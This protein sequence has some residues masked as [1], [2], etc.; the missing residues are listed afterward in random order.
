MAASILP[1]MMKDSNDVDGW[2]CKKCDQ[3]NPFDGDWRCQTPGCTGENPA[4]RKIVESSPPD[5]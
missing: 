1:G 4:L 3:K 2:R 5:A